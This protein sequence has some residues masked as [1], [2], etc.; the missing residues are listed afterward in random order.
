VRCHRISTALVAAFFLF[1]CGDDAGNR[2]ANVADV[3][4]TAPA[5]SGDA[6][7]ADS[8]APA[9]R[10]VVDPVSFNALIPLLPAAPTDWTAATPDGSTT[11]M[12]EYKVT[13]VTGQYSRAAAGDS[14]QADVTIQIT[15]GGFA[16][17]VAAPFQM[18]SMMS[19]ESTTGYQ[20]GVTIAGNPAY[21]VWDNGS[22]RCELHILVA[23]RF[24][25]HL[26][27]SQIPPDELRAW[28]DR[29]DLAGLADLAD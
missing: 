3:G 28:A 7:P 1:A 21:E 10:T 8:A 22:R 15:D 23:G 16:E 26:Q 11:S 6:E 24:L 18:M 17:M 29:I 4:D 19:H 5:D 25:V 27:S 14:P 13:F 20:K 12:P 9:A 2:V